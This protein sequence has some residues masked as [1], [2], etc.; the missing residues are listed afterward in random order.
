MAGGRVASLAGNDVQRASNRLHMLDMDAIWQNNRS[1]AADWFD[2]RCARVSFY[3]SV[4]EYLPAGAYE[5]LLR[6]G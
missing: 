1:D 3:H 2:R 6:N 4:K 5:G